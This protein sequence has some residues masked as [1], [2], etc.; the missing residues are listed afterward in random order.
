MFD[1]YHSL[2]I[3]LHFLIRSHEQSDYL[4]TNQITG[5]LWLFMELKMQKDY[6]TKVKYN[7]VWTK[8]GFVFDA[9]FSFKWM[10]ST[11]LV[12]ENHIFPHKL[13]YQHN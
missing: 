6:Q 12:I 3:E 8:D 4:K 1:Y 13:T 10:I 2:S 5:K 9:I 7:L 11:L